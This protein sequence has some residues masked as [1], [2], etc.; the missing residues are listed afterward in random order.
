M[1]KIILLLVIAAVAAAGYFF[2]KKYSDAGK[3]GNG[4]LVSCNGRLEATE[5]SIAT[6]LAGRIEEVMVLMG[7]TKIETTLIYCNIKQDNVR[8]SYRKYAA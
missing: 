4:R 2:Y 7:H 3:N 1:K 6:K 5:V 8:E